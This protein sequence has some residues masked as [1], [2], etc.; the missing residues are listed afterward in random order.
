[1]KKFQVTKHWCG[2]SRGYTIYEVEAE[3]LVDATEL[4]YD[5]K[6]IEHVVVRD[7]TEPEE[8]FAKEM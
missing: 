6:Q 7:D 4:Y 1:M 3:T 5:G 8:V 2:Y